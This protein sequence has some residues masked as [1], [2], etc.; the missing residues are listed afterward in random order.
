MSEFTFIFLEKVWSFLLL[1]IIKWGLLIRLY[2]LKE[3]L[4]LSIRQ[5]ASKLPADLFMRSLSFSG[6][7]RIRE[8]RASRN[9]KRCLL[10]GEILV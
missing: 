9:G 10:D 7:R 3:F 4:I 2:K 6:I 1:Q 8:I 5:A